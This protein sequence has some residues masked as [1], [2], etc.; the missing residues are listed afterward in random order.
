MHA[1]EGWGFLIDVA[2][3]HAPPVVPEEVFVPAVKSQEELQALGGWVQDHGGEAQP[4]LPEDF[5]TG[6]VCLNRF[7]RAFKV[8][9]K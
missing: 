6:L 1:S 7:L 3:R 8:S 4:L 5:S 9:Q 2:L